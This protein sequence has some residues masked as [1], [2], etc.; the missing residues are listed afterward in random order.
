MAY[1]VL[2][3]ADVERVWTGQAAGGGE[4]RCVLVPG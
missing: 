3:L 2:P 4:P 1:D